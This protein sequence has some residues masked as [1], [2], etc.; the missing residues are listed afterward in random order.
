MISHETKRI[1][2]T[3]GLLLVIVLLAARVL[4]LPGSFFGAVTRQPST[5]DRSPP[6]LI[7]A[8][9]VS[10]FHGARSFN[11]SLAGGGNYKWSFNV[12][13]GSMMINLTE[14]GSHA[15]VWSVGPQSPGSMYLNGVGFASFNWTAPASGNYQLTFQS[16]SPSQSLQPISPLVSVC[17]VQV[18]DLNPL[19]VIFGSSRPLA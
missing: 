14:S 10:V 2:G 16:S 9:N 5:L 7:F 1:L 17:Y 4:P 12:T 18:W 19:I 3:T 15:V 13:Y 8:D 6:S 11:L